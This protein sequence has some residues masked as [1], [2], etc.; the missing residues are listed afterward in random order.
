[1]SRP[2][3]PEPPA[4]PPPA[5]PVPP[6]PGRTS[7]FRLLLSIML[8][9]FLAVVDQT[10]VATAL[11]AIAGSMGGVERVSWV[12]VGYLV[13]T[14]I[15]APVYGQLGDQLGRRRLLVI[16]LLFFMT[17]SLLCAV[18][19]SVEM[20]T[21]MR[22]LQGLGGGGLM[23]LSQALIGETVPPLERAR[24]QGY[25]AAVMV[26]S[27][28]F[29]PVAGGFLTEHFGWQSVFL[30]NLPIGVLAILLVL[31]LPK[32]PGGG[33]P[34]RF[35]LLGVLLFAV[36]I[37]SG[38]VLMEQVRRFDAA[39]LPLALGLAALAAVS[40]VLLVW[41]EKTVAEPLL[42]VALLR[43][44]TTW[45]SDAL[46]ACHGAMLVSLLTFLPIYLRV[47]GGASPAET[48][49]LL[50]P[51]TIGVG[52]GS[53]V[54]GRAISR[55]G[56][57]AIFPSLGLIFV[58]LGLLVVALWSRYMTPLQLAGFLGCTAM[59]MG[60]VMGVVQLTIQVTAGQGKLGAAA[61]TVQFSRALGAALGTAT[62]GSVLFAVLGSQDPMA[63]DLFGELLQGG[64]ERLA[65]LPAATRSLIQDQIADAFRAAFLTIAGFATVALALAWSIPLRR[66]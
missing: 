23:T 40:L 47:V 55:T 14:T 13:A 26:S 15:A 44:P 62:V 41:R 4:A 66:I 9:M 24:Y 1:M 43:N 35:D 58:V 52:F 46:A 22:I 51:M 49:L 57:T 33:A 19:T 56:R 27:S 17:A 2:N 39:L 42:P 54:T 5:D 36:F 20:L 25:L 8:P 10:I 65:A 3:E 38:L 48:G 32:R 53:M 61:A 64:S 50:L 30:V 18:S 34:F 12:V 31:R 60:T 16:A 28:T 29:G 6:A 59:F 11:P 21:A 37:A 63:A 7:F 45:R